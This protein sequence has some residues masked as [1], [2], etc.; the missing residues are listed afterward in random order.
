MKRFTRSI[1]LLG[2]LFASLVVSATEPK[3]ACVAALEKLNHQIEGNF[4]ETRRDFERYIET[5]PAT[6]VKDLSHLSS[7]GHW[8]DAGSGEGFALQDYFNR[9]VFD[10]E[11]ALR[12]AAPGFG[13]PRKL[14]LDSVVLRESGN[15][16]NQKTPKERGRITGVTYKMERRDP[17]VEGLRI[18]SGRFFEDIPNEEIKRADIITDLYGVMSYSPRVDKVLSKYHATLKKGG[19]AYIFLGDYIETPDFSISL[20][21][22]PHQEMGWD[23]PFALSKVKKK[24]GERVSLL[25]WVM[26]LPGFRAR[27]EANQVEPTSTAG[28]L[29]GV[30]QRTTL[31]LEKVEDSADIPPLRLL[32]ADEG[33]P[34]T[35]FFE[36]VSE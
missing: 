3:G 16:L 1:F 28:V 7:E 11:K 17:Q 31:V 29:P 26:F 12:N 10:P 15:R 33:K 5:F 34:P 9:K 27:L 19:R 13:R 30:R 2:F 23:A 35:R 20:R 21:A 36:E 32:E 14:N 25:E 8:L 24:N 4:F 6:L 18:L 22:M